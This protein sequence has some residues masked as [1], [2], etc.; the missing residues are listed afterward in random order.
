M[1]RQFRYQ[2]RI[3]SLRV[4]RRVLL[5]SRRLPRSFFRNLAA[6]YG[7]LLLFTLLVSG[8]RNNPGALH[9]FSQLAA[10]GVTSM[11]QGR[12]EMVVP[13]MARLVPQ[14]DLPKTLL[15]QALPILESGP[16]P[17][18]AMD[19]YRILRELIKVVARFDPGDPRTFIAAGL[20]RGTVPTRPQVEIEV[21]PQR[22]APPPP[23]LPPPEPSPSP[24]V[25]RWGQEPIVGLYHTHNSETYHREGL[26]PRRF[27]DYHL[28]NTTD[29][30]IMRVGGELARTLEEKH[31]IPVLHSRALHDQDGFLHSYVNSLRTAEGMVRE[32]PQLEVILDI[33]RDGIPDLD[34]LTEIG[35]QPVARILI[36]VTTDAYGL[37]HPRWREN[38]AF[39]RVLHDR[40]ETM[41]PG[42]SR[43]V[44]IVDTARYNQ[45]VHPRALLL[46]IGNYNH[47]EEPALRAAR[48]FADV[49]A[50]ALQDL[51]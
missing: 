16:E 37:P 25:P 17:N 48:L 13:A 38:L 2:L 15:Q 29:T 47:W 40:M 1:F 41:Y 20:P 33:H 50:A 4:R 42:L 8:A 23:T 21:P 31:G 19:G 24:G 44:R 26:D 28:H 7:V 43:G 18:T 45:H 36:I 30:G 32:N 3:T 39:A 6:F 49:L 9:N 51:P 11:V 27:S 22:P 5:L 10:R 35:G 14:G 12:E 34:L 46:E